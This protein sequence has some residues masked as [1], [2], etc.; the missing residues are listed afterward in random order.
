M[1][2]LALAVAHD[3][4]CVLKVKLTAQRAGTPLA[5]QTV[6]A[7]ALAALHADAKSMV[8]TPPSGP[9]LTQHLTILRYLAEAAPSA[10]LAGANSM[11]TAHVDQWLHFTWQDIG[12]S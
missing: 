7:S 12:T 5:I 2:T 3:D 10:S 9:P 8:L 1:A 11:E 4:Y 6:T